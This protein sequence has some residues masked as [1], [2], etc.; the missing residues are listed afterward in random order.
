MINHDQNRDADDPVLATVAEGSTQAFYSPLWSGVA[1]SSALPIGVDYHP[2]FVRLLN[3]IPKP[4]RAMFTAEQF[5]VLSRA[6][7]TPAA[8]HLVDYRVSIPFFGRRFYAVVLFGRERRDLQRL[9]NEGQ[10]SSW[11]VQIAYYALIVGVAGVFTLFTIIALY[12]AKSALGIDLSDGPS[13]LHGW[14]Y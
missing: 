6:T 3:Q 8:R 13:V 14:V 12:V 9:G 10:L 11:R 1:Q 5:G 2:G 7:A 4:L